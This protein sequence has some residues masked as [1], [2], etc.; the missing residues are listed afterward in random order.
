VLGNQRL[1]Q[2]RLPNKINEPWVWNE[3]TNRL[4]KRALSQAEVDQ[5]MNELISFMK[6]TSPAG[7]NQPLAWQDTF[8]KTALGANMVSEETLIGL[9]D[10]FFGPKPI[11]QS[12][13]LT[14][15]AKS[16][17][18]ME[19]RYGN[20]WTQNSGLDIELLWVVKQIRLDGTPTKFRT[21]NRMNDHW[22]GICDS[23]LE[24]GDHE[25]S[26]DFECAYVDT[27][28]LVGVDASTLPVE[29]WP[30]SRKQWSTTVSA[31]LKI[32]SERR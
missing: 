20:P 19:I 28:K 17:L 4:N 26:I 21:L 3:L 8:I 7:W 2:S 15:R 10:A 24:S 5:A 11:I 14:A 18:Q 27:G 29:Q 1:I 22:V 23:D 31:P 6:T 30:T 32:S 25:I 13:P 9:S 12:L 16:P